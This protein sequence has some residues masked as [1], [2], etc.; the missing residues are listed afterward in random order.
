MPARIG[1]FANQQ[2]IIDATLRTQTN[3]TESQLQV[4]T[5]KKTQTF[6]GLARHA[7]AL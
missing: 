3:L 7:T 6:S 4:A 1:S 2:L 5:G